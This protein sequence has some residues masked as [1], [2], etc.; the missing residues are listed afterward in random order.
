MSKKGYN[1]PPPDTQLPIPPPS[2]PPKHLD[3]KREWREGLADAEARIKQLE[4]EIA[5]LLENSIETEARIEALETALAAVVRALAYGETTYPNPNTLHKH[6][7]CDGETARYLAT[8]AVALGID[9]GLLD[10]ED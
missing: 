2:L 6:S 5:L 7:L 1:P 8:A 10:E 3:N 4:T 9:V